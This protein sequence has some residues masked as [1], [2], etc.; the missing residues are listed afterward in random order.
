V[1]EIRRGIRAYELSFYGTLAFLAGFFGSRLFATLNPTVVVMQS[2]IHFH[3]F[4]YGLGMVTLAGW[5]GIAYNKPRLVQTYAIVFGLGAG[6]IADEVGLLLTFGDY[7]SRL[8]TDFFVGAI[9]F[10]VLVSI[11]VRYRKLLAKDLV[12]ASWNERLI[13]LGITLCGLSAI[14]FAVDA[15]TQ[16]VLVA[17]LGLVVILSGFEAAKAGVVAGL[18]SGIILAAGNYL[19]FQ[20]S[21]I[22]TQI[23]QSTP[24]PENSGITI[25]YL[26]TVTLVVVALASFLTALIG[27]AVL[28]LLFSAVHNRYLRSR[29]LRARGIVFGMVLWAIDTPFILSA[30]QYGAVFVV[31]S[32]GLG[33]FGSLVYGYLLG[34]LFPRFTR[35]VAGMSGPGHE[36]PSISRTASSILG[37]RNWKP[38][39]SNRPG[40]TRR[41]LIISSASVL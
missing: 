16:G 38:A 27:G 28:G 7:Q 17:G 36:L 10:I 13:Y 15:S 32:L 34:M 1:Q 25:D 4:W 26:V 12:H 3:H 33:L 41:L 35:R 37:K 2:G 40:T 9:G 20:F 11:T 39:A 24:L 19:V 23:F 21:G 18:V 6:L 29:S 22:L 31:L 30:V 14:F 5:L 8:T